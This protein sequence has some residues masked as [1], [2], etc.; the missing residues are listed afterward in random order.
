MQKYGRKVKSKNFKRSSL[1]KDMLDDPV[2]FEAFK[3]EISVRIEA[4]I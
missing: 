3:S 2:L 4:F 1:T